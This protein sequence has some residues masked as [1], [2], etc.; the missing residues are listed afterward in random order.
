MYVCLYSYVSWLPRIRGL[1]DAAIG[2]EAIDVQGGSLFASLQEKKKR[3]VLRTERGIV[4][5]QSSMDSIGW[6][7]ADLIWSGLAAGE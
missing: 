6:N 5:G 7:A 3:R 2:A 4:E 1:I